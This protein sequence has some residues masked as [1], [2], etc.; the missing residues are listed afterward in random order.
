MV[1]VIVVAGAG[2]YA[3]QAFQRFQDASLAA[4]AAD[5]ATGGSALPDEPFVLFR[6]TASGQGYG[7]AATVLLSAPEGGRTVGGAACDRVYGTSGQ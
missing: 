1:T 6:N 2:I 4:S 5:I 3:A 7:Q